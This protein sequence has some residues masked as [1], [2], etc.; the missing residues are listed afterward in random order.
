M[1][2][3]YRRDGSLRAFWFSRKEAE[4]FVADPRNVSY[5]GDIVTGPCPSCGAWHASRPEWLLNTNVS[6]ED[7]PIR[8]CVCTE[9]MDSNFLILT[10]GTAVHEKCVRPVN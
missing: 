5:Q 9:I 2:R 8:C 10:D 3:C 7:D 1:S 6:L 4:A